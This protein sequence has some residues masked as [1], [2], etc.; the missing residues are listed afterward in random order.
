MDYLSDAH[1]PIP[2]SSAAW[3]TMLSKNRFWASMPRYT[4]ARKVKWSCW[5]AVALA[6]AL[7]E[8]VNQDARLDCLPAEHGNTLYIYCQ[9]KSN[10]F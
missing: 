6:V 10:I 7:D 4:R 2:R 5:K 8:R 1:I 3:V 9:N